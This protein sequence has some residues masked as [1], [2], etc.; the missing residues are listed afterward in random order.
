MMHSA[1]DRADSLGSKVL[2][3]AAMHECQAQQLAESCALAGLLLH[4]T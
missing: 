2:C 3:S 4:P 1:A